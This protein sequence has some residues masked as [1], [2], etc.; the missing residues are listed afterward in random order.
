MRPYGW[1]VPGM[2]IPQGPDEEP[3]RLSPPKHWRRDIITIPRSLPSMNDNVMR[4]RGREFHHLKLDLQEEIGMLLLVAKTPR[5]NKRAVAG[6]LLRF[7]EHRRRDGSNW[8]PLIDKALGDA[9]V[10]SS[11]TS[12][13]KRYI[14]DD[15]QEFYSFGGCEIE[16]DI[17][18]P[19]VA[20]YLYTQGEDCA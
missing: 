2:R 16:E 4:G 17:G 3:I 5:R 1:F 8:V 10:I 11:Q 13:E 15:T 19:R 20:I 14:P 9:L 18:K 6:A 12:V 7:P